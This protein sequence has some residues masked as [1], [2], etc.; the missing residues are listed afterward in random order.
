M[1]A[2]RDF[3]L[4]QPHAR[5]DSAFYD[6]LRANARSA[7]MRDRFTIPPFQ[8]RSF[9]VRKGQSFRIVQAPRF[10][11]GKKTANAKFLKVVLNDE[12]IHE[13]VE[14]KGPTTACLTGKENPILRF[15]WTIAIQPYIEQDNLY[16]M[17]NMTNFNA[18]RG[19]TGDPLTVSCRVIPTYICP[20]NPAP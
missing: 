14:V 3:T 15:N 2:L 16:K 5:L 18:N 6:R 1:A 10:E 8:G 4:L 9:I 7:Q 19:L 13:N 12:V 20:S 17:W 11:D